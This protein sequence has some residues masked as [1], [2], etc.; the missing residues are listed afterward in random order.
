[1]LCIYESLFAKNGRILY[2]LIYPVLYALFPILAKEGFTSLGSEMYTAVPNTLQVSEMLSREKDR[3]VVATFDKKVKFIVNTTDHPNLMYQTS[4]QEVAE[5]ILDSKL[6]LENIVTRNK[7]IHIK[8]VGGERLSV[9]ISTEEFTTGDTFLVLPPVYLPDLYEY[10]AVSVPKVIIIDEGEVIDPTE[11]SAFIIVG[12]ED[13]TIVNVSV[14]QNISFPGI[15]EDIEVGIP[16]NLVLNKRETLYISH[17][18]DLS[19]SRVVA[20]KPIAFIT[21]HECGNLPA[22]HSFCDQMFEQI[23]PTSTW[24]QTFFTAPLSTRKRVDHFKFIASKDN[25]DIT[26]AC[27]SVQPITVAKGMNAGDVVGIDILST[28]YCQFISD[29][30]VLLMQFSVGESVDNVTNADPFMVM[31]PPIKQFRNEYIFSVL[32]SGLDENVQYFINIVMEAKF[33]RN[34]LL[35]NN[36]NITEDWTEINCVGDVRSQCAYGIQVAINAS[37]SP[38][39]ISHKNQSAR[40]GVTVYS[41]GYRFGEGYTAGVN[42]YPLACKLST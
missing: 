23:P 40:F 31:V 42:Q 8:S 34:S 37:T 10:Y 16:I 35:I 22:D 19:G 29:K 6:K 14:K 28:Q 39:I 2:E 1:M 9:V 13:D 20:N 12:C 15:G 38:Y 3:L 25:T 5:V 4:I 18:E 11:K 26:G 24:G 33:N 32:Q 17:V 27:G 36:V 41:F 7:G 30:P 21:G